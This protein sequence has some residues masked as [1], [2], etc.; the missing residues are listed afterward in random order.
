MKKFTA[1]LL[2]V[3]LVF[4]VSVV[5]FAADVYTCPTCNKKYEGIEAY[6][7]CIENHS[8]PAEESGELF[9]CGTCHKKYDNIEE[10]NACVDDHFNNVNYH[11]DKYIDLTIVEL[12]SSFVEIFN[13]T[14]IKELFTDIIEKVVSFIG[15]IADSGIVSEIAA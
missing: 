3:I 12:I 4:S 1:I 2:A 13:N 14:G 9:E 6:N 8:K 7:A 5:A 11:Y 15:G 10:Y